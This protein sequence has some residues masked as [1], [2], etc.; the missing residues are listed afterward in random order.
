MLLQ[1]HLVAEVRGLA[2][3]RHFCN[4]KLGLSERQLATATWPEVAHR[5]VQVGNGQP[6]SLSLMLR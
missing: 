4:H 1:G 5:L 6:F 3:V 2:E